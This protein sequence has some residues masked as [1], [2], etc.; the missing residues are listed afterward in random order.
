MRD[1]NW[2]ALV[3]SVVLFIIMMFAAVGMDYERRNGPISTGIHC[4][5]ECKRATIFL[6]G[7]I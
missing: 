6:M 2:P 7:V 3:I 5:A 1:S 4:D